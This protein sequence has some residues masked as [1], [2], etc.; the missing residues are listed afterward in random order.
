[1]AI[2]VENS[3][4]PLSEQSFKPSAR[5]LITP[6][7]QQRVL[8]QE[9]RRYCEGTIAGRSFLIAGH[10]GA[11]KTTLVAM[12]VLETWLAVE[13]KPEFLRPLFIPLH[14]P[15]LFP[16]L[17][18]AAAPPPK[19]PVDWTIAAA[20]A[21]AAAAP[22]SG[23]DGADGATPA[24][25][26]KPRDKRPS[27]IALEQIILGLHRAVARE[28]VRCY[29]G[30]VNDLADLRHRH[31]QRRAELARLRETGVMPGLDV[32]FPGDDDLDR[33]L[34]GLPPERELDELAAQFEIELYGGP[35]PQR[36]REL[37]TRA[38]ALSGGVLFR[39]GYAPLKRDIA[40]Q[41]LTGLPAGLRLD[42]PGVH[43][44]G[45]R[46]LAA[47][48]GVVEAFRRISGDVKR[49]EEEKDELTRTEER[50]SSFTLAVKDLVAP[51]TALLT[52]ALA[53]AG[54]AASAPGHG[55]RSVVA[56]IVAALGAGLVFKLSKQ[57]KR[58]RHVAREQQFT[59][60]LS[61]A[62]LD[63]V[64]PM[65][66]ERLREAG[67]APVF[68]VDELDKVE[69]LG[70]RILDMVRQLK[71]LVAENAFFCFLTNRSYFEHMLAE[72]LGKPYPK[73]YTYYTH[74]LFVAFSAEDVERNLRERIPE[75]LPTAAA[76]TADIAAAADTE[77]VA[78]R[79][80]LRWVLRYRSQ[81]HA[82][83]LERE[84]AALRAGG[85]EVTAD[86]RALLS[87]P[88]N[89]IAATFQVAI[90]LWMAQVSVREAVAERPEL[91]RLLNDAMYYLPRIWRGDRKP[92]DTADEKS[93]ALPPLSESRDGFDAFMK[94]M[95]GRTDREEESPSGGEE[96]APAPGSVSPQ[97]SNGLNREDC[98]FLYGYVCL[99]ADFLSDRPAD[100]GSGAAAMP[101]GKEDPV[102]RE[103]RR[104]LR[105]EWS[106]SRLKRGLPA[107]E[108]SV[109]EALLIPRP[110]PR[111]E[112]TA[113]PGASPPDSLLQRVDSAPGEWRYRF[114]YDPVSGAL[115]ERASAPPTDLPFAALR[116]A[117]GTRPRKRGSKD[118]RPPAVLDA[119][120]LDDVDFIAAFASMLLR[121]QED[122]RSGTDAE[123]RPSSA[124]GLSIDLG[125]LASAF[126]VIPLSPSWSVV[127]AAA[128][129]LL[130]AKARGARYSSQGEDELL[131]SQFRELL[132]RNG[133]RIGRA[134]ACGAFVGRGT[135]TSRRPRI[136]R[137]L[138]MI[139]L[140]HAL[141]RRDEEAVR[142]A[143]E[144]VAAQVRAIFLV[145]VD[146]QRVT[147]SS[148][149]DLA[150][151]EQAVA[152]AIERAEGPLVEV[153]Q[154][155]LDEVE[156]HAWMDLLD[157]LEHWVTT[158]LPGS[159]E[160]VEITAAARLQGPFA[161]LLRFDP[162][163]MTIA[164][165][166]RVLA[167]A[168]RGGSSA[169]EARATPAW[170]APIALHALGFHGVAV[171][172]DTARRWLRWPLPNQ[173]GVPSLSEWSQV[174]SLVRPGGLFTGTLP[175]ATVVMIRRTASPQLITWLPTP[176]FAALIATVEELETIVQGAPD[177]PSLPLI[178]PT[179]QQVVAV[180]MD[181]ELPSRLEGSLYTVL[182]SSM[183]RPW[184]V[185]VYWQDR[186]RE[187]RHP[188]VV[189]PTSLADIVEAAAKE[190][191][192]LPRK[193]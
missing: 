57:R 13:R 160:I 25:A 178:A 152:A 71:K 193:A 153:Q 75:P 23:K 40:P 27:E 176:P 61:T 142:T 47:L 127:E 16:P 91:Q 48:S 29:Y 145:N 102:S 177:V 139:A 92:D 104:R 35:S 183:S 56:G 70:N 41:T 125:M 65:L 101:G 126:G 86:A 172:S 179:E 128:G 37:W 18:K 111:G 182:A 106:D 83:D 118:K 15:N 32:P 24:D 113:R 122:P 157:R 22:P 52:G 170:L 2:R 133:Y 69:R 96:R 53:G 7:H 72:G 66:I 59:E 1:M 173:I 31:Q 123:K 149:A 8:Q 4:E 38:D 58:D 147:L 17:P 159:P 84:L 186:G 20:S 28:F 166:V 136:D 39:Q 171:E 161:V 49:K 143:L 87:S 131:V 140:A 175:T 33:L 119:K 79:A 124:K 89:R 110:A 114:R 54:A 138:T 85:D 150:P 137:G 82:V 112:T 9:L 185:H 21:T 46:E 94:Y 103:W 168:R 90:E 81:L 107:L 109:W 93:V 51:A 74:R 43:A 14:G 108:P 88:R 26:A 6:S 121:L 116:P 105:D 188:Y 180:E 192:P 190:R 34:R 135:S 73:E 174:Q 97:G 156:H 117:E 19:K 78:A 115:R 100:D 77:E 146:P 163:E 167:G 189:N 10:R 130:D 181:P 141:T 12:A 151:Y 154:A 36:L 184:I 67:L 129:R 11:G 169:P 42:V 134:L 64:L 164:D 144:D 30:R 120:V 80:L 76:G 155:I 191:V 165:W 50:G 187:M 3:P 44:Q 158:G 132:A 62:T 162:R 55:L 60:D 148:I 99:L 45:V 68:V 63:R 98:A 95:E 5:P